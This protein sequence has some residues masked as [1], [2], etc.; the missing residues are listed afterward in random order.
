MKVLAILAATAATSAYAGDTTFGMESIG[1]VVPY[2]T[3]Q[4][5]KD[6]LI[7]AGYIMALGDDDFSYVT[8]EESGVEKREP[9]QVRNIFH[10]RDYDIFTSQG[11]K[12]E[13]VATLES[14]Q[15]VMINFREGFRPPYG[16]FDSVDSAFPEQNSCAAY[17]DA[18]M[19]SAVK[20]FIR[21]NDAL[22]SVEGKYCYYADDD[23]PDPTGKNISRHGWEK[24]KQ[25]S[26]RVDY[27]FVNVEGEQRLGGLSVVWTDF[28]VGYDSYMSVQNKLKDSFDFGAPVESRF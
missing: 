15:V 24:L 7:A 25:Q 6:A 20:W 12:I 8:V 9:Y 28:E 5:A 16:N 19:E 3:L 27:G 17:K 1:G 14:D 2:S 22:A 11:V 18:N 10:S 13:I 26:L 21:N 23:F 4:E